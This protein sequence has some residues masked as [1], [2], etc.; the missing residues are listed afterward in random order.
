MSVKH[1]ILYKKR[2][3]VILVIIIIGISALVLTRQTKHFGKNVSM[4]ALLV[5]T[6][7][8]KSVPL[9]HYVSTIGTL[10][11]SNEVVLTSEING[12]IESIQFQ[13]GDFVRAGTLLVTVKHDSEEA[14]LEKTQAEYEQV[15]DQF[16]RSK[17]LYADHFIAQADIVQIQSK[18]KIAQ[19][20]LDQAKIDLA[21]CFIKAPFSGKLG[22]RDI[23]IGQYVRSGDKIVKLE[24]MPVDFADFS[25]SETAARWLVNAANITIYPGGSHQPIQ[26]VMS[27]IDSGVDTNTRNVNVRAKLKTASENLI[28]GSFATIIIT[29]PYQKTGLVIPNIAIQYEPYGASVYVV[30]QGSVKLRYIQTEPYREDQVIVTSGLNE[31]EIIVVRGQDKLHDGEQVKIQ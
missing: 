14:I 23:N 11:S 30:N 5:S 12:T 20:N 15:N 2:W 9:M 25:V 16:Q 13:S 1:I 10:K 22:I 29:I 19:A 4:P 17:K 24:S 18:L 27:A 31:G 8:V 6:Q 26:A 3:F 21:K 7:R 28:P